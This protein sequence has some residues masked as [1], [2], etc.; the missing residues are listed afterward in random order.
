MIATP[1]ASKARAMFSIVLSKAIA[2][3]YHR[4]QPR[5]AGVAFAEIFDQRPPA[6]TVPSPACDKTVLHTSSWSTVTDAEADR[7]VD[8]RSWRGR[9]LQRVDF[10]GV[11][12]RGADFSGADL[13]AAS[14]RD[15]RL[16]VPPRVGVVVLGGAMIIASCAGLAIGWVMSRTRD[17]FSSDNWDEVAE[18]G[19][20]ALVML[21]MVATLLW[22][23]F[24]VAIRVVTVSY[25]ALV[26]ANVVANLIWDEVGEC[27]ISC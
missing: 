25:L 23:G 21:I 10:A 8:P 12:L 15:A 7:R 13:T 18:G 20:I 14:F 17:Q 27:P 11:D 3:T 24:D 4:L 2:E 9:T 5:S 6:V 1:T 19:T 22:R 26:A 16:G